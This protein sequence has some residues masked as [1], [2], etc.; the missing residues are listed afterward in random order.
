MKQLLTL[1]ILC[2]VA[3]NI[4]AQLSNG[5]V[6]HYPFS[7][8]ATDAIGTVD[9]TVSNAT[10]TTDRFGTANSAYSFTSTGSNR[11]FI[12]FGNNFNG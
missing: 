5:L 2:F 3:M 11:S 12:D 9:G 8:D 1:F 7:G 6:A 4:Q 10:L